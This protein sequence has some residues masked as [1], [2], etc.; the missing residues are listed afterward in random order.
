[1]KEDEVGG[2]WSTHGTEDK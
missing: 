1:M 2:T